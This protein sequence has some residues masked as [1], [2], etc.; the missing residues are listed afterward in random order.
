MNKKSSKSSKTIKNKSIASFTPMDFSHLL[1]HVKGIDDKLMKIHFELYHGLVD[2]TNGALHDLKKNNKA[3]DMVAYSSIKKQFSFFFNGMRLHEIY[4]DVMDGKQNGRKHDEIEMRNALAKHFGSYEAWKEDFMTTG[5]IPGVGFVAL[6]YDKDTEK[7]MN[8]WI[9]EFQ[10][11]ELIGC[12]LLLV[13][14]MWEHAF[15]AEFGLNT[16]KYKE[17]FLDNVNWTKVADKLFVI[18]QCVD[19]YGLTF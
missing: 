10:I 13:M 2:A 4:F 8:I 16:K 6:V 1:G 15:I 12:E 3:K 17:V 9:N 19:E 7:M 18:E 5:N 14:D 11:G